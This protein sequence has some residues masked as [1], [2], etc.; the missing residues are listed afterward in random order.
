MDQAGI[1]NI[2]VVADEPYTEGEIDFTNVLNKVKNQNPE[3]LV[4][5]MQTVDCANALNAIAQMGW[6]IDVVCPGCERVDAGH[7]AGR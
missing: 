6:D 5:V 2:T 1:D 4:L 3:L 7:R